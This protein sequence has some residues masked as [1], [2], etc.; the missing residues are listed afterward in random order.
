MSKNAKHELRRQEI[1]EVMGKYKD[2][3][4]NIDLSRLRKEDNKTYNKISYY[5][6]SIDEALIA[7]GSQNTEE[8]RGADKGAPVNRKTLRNELAFDMLTQLREKY[9][10]EEIAQSYGCSRAHVN[11]LFQS[12]AKSVGAANKEDNEDVAK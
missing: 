6:G 9:T 1:L 5:F 7:C 4:G 2:E 10:L 11:Q 8:E 12:L 3:F